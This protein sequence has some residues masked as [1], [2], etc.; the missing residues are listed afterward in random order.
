VE[1]D[2]GTLGI[3]GPFTNH[4]TVRAK[5]GGTASFAPTAIVTN[6]A[7]ATQTL[8]GGTWQAMADSA[9]S[10][11]GNPAVTTNAAGVTLSGA[12]SVFIPINSLASNAAGGAFRVLGGRSFT[13]TGGL[14]NA[15][16][17]EVGTGSTLSVSGTYTQTAGE[18]T[19]NG[20]LAGTGQVDLQ[21]G[22]LTGSGSVA[23]AV[24]IAM[25]AS[26]APGNSTGVLTFEEGVDLGGIYLWQLAA[27]QD[28]S[29]GVAGSA[30]DQLLVTGGDVAF[31]GVL[32]LDFLN[33]TTPDPGEAFWQGD[34]AW[35]ILDNVG[36]G[37]TTLTSALISGY[38]GGSGHFDLGLGGTGN[39]LVLRWT[40]VPEP[41]SLGLLALGVMLTFVVRRRLAACG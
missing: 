40:A 22:T 27:L 41:A 29:D 35:T 18:T 4:G 8:T 37:T 24:A 25:A 31:D 7:A 10:F 3:A 26:V 6:Y 34:H 12:G 5:N 1:A 2:T 17:V 20:L 28:D 21:G 9:L 15:G 36:S 13:S 19:V 23:Q 33:G 16:R 38:A 39:D 14:T 11:N 30:F 32:G